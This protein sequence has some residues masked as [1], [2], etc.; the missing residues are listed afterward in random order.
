MHLIEFTGKIKQKMKS[1]MQTS[2]KEHLRL[3][4]K[5]DSISKGRPLKQDC[6]SYT[7]SGGRITG[8]ESEIKDSKQKEGKNLNYARLK[9]KFPKISNARKPIRR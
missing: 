6:V 5:A 7:I 3:L 2:T 8:A 1:M 4:A 9:D